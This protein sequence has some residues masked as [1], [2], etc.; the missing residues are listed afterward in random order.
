[1]HPLYACH[2]V[3]LIKTSHPNMQIYKDNVNKRRTEVVNEDNVR[4]RDN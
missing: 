1:M 2:A 4:N 3:D